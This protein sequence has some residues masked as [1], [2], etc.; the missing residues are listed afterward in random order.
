MCVHSVVDIVT[1]PENTT[2]CRGSDVTISCGYQWASRLYV[3]WIINGTSFDQSAIVNSPL[4]QLNNPV[5]PM[6]VSL[7]IFSINDTT[8]VKCI[9]HS[10]PNTTSSTL[11]K[12]SVTGMHVYLY[13]CS[14]S[15]DI[16]MYSTTH[17][18]LDAHEY[19]F[20]SE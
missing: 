18:S 16:R 19:R 17:F 11:G 13:A 6:R 15:M 4:Y 7:T 3:T 20:A 1:P 14:T 8:T 9:V 5:T 12:I 10:T 2:V